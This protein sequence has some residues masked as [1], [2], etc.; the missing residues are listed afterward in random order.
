MAYELKDFLK[1]QFPE[2]LSKVMELADCN[3]DPITNYLQ[4][5]YFK[6]LALTHLQNLGQREEWDAHLSI[7]LLTNYVRNVSTLLQTWPDSPYDHFQ[8]YQKLIESI[9]LNLD[10]M[11]NCRIWLSNSLSMRSFLNMLSREHGKQALDSIESELED[12][13][14]QLAKI[15]VKSSEPVPRPNRWRLKQFHD[16]I[17]AVYIERTTDNIVYQNDLIPLPFY[18]N[19]YKVFQPADTVQLAKWAKEVKSCVLSRQDQILSKKSK[20]AL[21]ED[22]GKPMYTAE[23]SGEPGDFTIREIRGPHNS[24]LTPKQVTLCDSLIKEAAWRQMSGHPASPRQKI[25]HGDSLK[26]ICAD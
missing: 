8:T 19:N 16:Y 24:T 4:G 26:F 11:A 17:S 6:K 21:I 22:G 12:T 15:L 18:N 2:R 20:I 10:H 14:K 25:E 7:Y 9:I 1:L 3:L 23:L 13:L 5:P